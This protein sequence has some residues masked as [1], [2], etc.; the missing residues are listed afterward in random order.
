MNDKKRVMAFVDGFNLYHAID[1]LDIDPKTKRPRHQKQHLKWLNLL[2][3]A[4]AFAPPTREQIV[5]VY[6]FSAFATWRP[7]A[8]QRHLDYVRALESVGVNVVMGNFKKK[9]R[10]CNKCNTTWIGHE[11]KESDVNLALYLLD[12]AY[13]NAY[14]KAFL[15]TADTD[16]VPAIK[17]VRSN[18]PQKE[19]IALIPKNRFRN[20]ME[21]RQAC[22][23][24]SRIEESHLERNLFPDSITLSD[25]CSVTRP[26]KYRPP[27][28]VE[29]V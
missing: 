5:S 4:S 2:A 1:D 22:N 16:L 23:G 14:D 8:Y 21:L 9:H 17:M 6:Y 15:V 20:A 10:Q 27:K 28:K 13:Q 26:T 25:S 12:L 7:D 19:V 3:M 24:A 11:E 29:N 18:F